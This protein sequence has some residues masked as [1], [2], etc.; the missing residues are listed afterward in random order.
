MIRPREVKAPGTGRPP[1]SLRKRLV[2]GSAALIALAAILIGVVSVLSLQGFLVGRLDNQLLSASSRS[3]GALEGRQFDSGQRPPARDFLA[4]PGQSAGTIAGLASSSGEIVA[5]VLGVKGGASSLTSEQLDTLAGLDQINEPITVSLGGDLGDYRMIV[6]SDPVTGDSLIVGLPLSDVQATVLQLTILVAGIGVLAIAVAAIAGAIAVRFALRPLERVASTATRVS[7][8]QLDRG[9]VALAERVSLDDADPR[10]EVGQMGSALNRL[11]EH[12]ASA[13]TARQAS[14]DKVRSFVADASHELRTPLASIRGYAEL[15]RRGGHEIPTDVAHAIGRIEAESVRM[16]GLVESLL[17]LARLDESA[18]FEHRA[19]DVSQLLIE[20]V[21]DAAV[22]GPDHE[23]ELQFP[24]DA[25]VVTGDSARLH[26]VVANLL[27][28]ARIH[29]PAGT[30]VTAS[31]STEGSRAIIEVRDTGP[32]IAAELQAKVFERFVRGDSSRSRAAGS[33]GLGLA[34][35]A[36]VVES[37]G[38]TSSVS[39]EPGNT[40]FRVELPTAATA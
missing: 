4:L 15:T 17:L 32:G 23:W 3:Q 26:Q 31:L 40:V 2:L 1:L 9:A 21:G 13:L 35:V 12:V 25:V 27:A 14:E 34:I 7:E 29:T 19:V 38:G 24:D 36:A 28:N 33:T 16:T 18:P 11:L 10:T 37:L 20:A 39:S 5:G 8:L 6:S 30:S 22:A